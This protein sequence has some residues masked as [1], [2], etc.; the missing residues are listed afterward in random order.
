MR[1]GYVAS[2]TSNKNMAVEPGA[3]IEAC[4]SGIDPESDAKSYAKDHATATEQPAYVYRVSIESVIG[5]KVS[6]EVVS[7]ATPDA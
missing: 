3:V 5:Y 6:K 1:I 2:T 7:F 4:F